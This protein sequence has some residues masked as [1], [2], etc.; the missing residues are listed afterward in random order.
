M[1]HTKCRRRYRQKTLRLASLDTDVL[2]LSMLIVTYISVT[3]NSIFQPDSNNTSF[4]LTN[5]V[6]NMTMSASLFNNFHKTRCP[7][8]HNHCNYSVLV[9]VKGV[10][11]FG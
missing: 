1:A 3:G 9:F 6:S 11:I 5:K 8:V 10:K 7:A 2:S 4:N